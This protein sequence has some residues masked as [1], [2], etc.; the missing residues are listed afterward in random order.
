KGAYTPEVRSLVREYVDA[1]CA[2]SRVGG[3]L[4]ATGKAFGAAVSHSI[5]RKTVARAV[6]EAG[7]A[8]DIQLGME[9]TLAPALSHSA[10]GTT[11]GGVTH[12][13]R[14]VTMLTP[15]YDD[16]SLP[17]THKNRLLGIEKTLSH[18][19]EAQFTGLRQQ[20]DRISSRFT[21]SPL[22]KRLQLS[23]S[24]DDFA[25]KLR[26][27]HG[28]H[29]KDVIKYARLLQ[30]DWKKSVTRR[31][32]GFEKLS[33]ILPFPEHCT[34]FLS[35]VFDLAISNAGGSDS[36]DG[37]DGEGQT[38]SLM[39]AFLSMVRKLGDIAFEELPENVQHD[40]DWSVRVGCCMH[41]EMNCG[42]GFCDGMADSW[43]RI[44]GAT[45][46][47]L[48]ANKAN[49]NA[50]ARSATDSDAAR[51]AVKES[52]RGGPKS[53]M[54]AGAIYNNKGPDKG[55]Q[56]MFRMYWLPIK[57]IPGSKRLP[58]VNFA[59]TSANRFQTTF[60]AACDLIAYLSEHKTYLYMVRDR[61]EKPRW[62]HMEA[63]LFLSLEDDATVTELCCMA[64]AYNC[65]F[66]PYTR[67]ARR[68]GTNHLDLKKLHDDLLSFIRRAIS[69]PDLLINYSAATVRASWPLPWE[70]SKSITAL[71]EL[72]PTLPFF[73]PVFLAGLVRC[74]ETW[75]RFTTEFADDGLIAR[76]TP[77]ER[78]TPSTND[79]N[80]G[81]LG[82]TRLETGAHPTQTIELT[83]AKI[84]RNHNGTEKF[85]KVFFGP[86]DHRSVMATQRVAEASGASG[87]F[88]DLFLDASAQ[89]VATKRAAAEKKARLLAEKMA[90]LAAVGLVLDESVIRRMLDAQ[91]QVQLEVYRTIVKDTEVPIKARLKRKPE[92]L[93][94]VI[95]A[96]QRY[97]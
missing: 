86:D 89:A 85:M 70:H 52:S 56:D 76:S 87:V 5:S 74:L 15:N 19:A 20:L 95:A 29:A 1:G 25:R 45:P 68:E 96:L 75:E 91:L 54:L 81:S 11:I 61:K 18:T 9:M 3:L 77:L 82:E 60:V 40:L 35:A 79:A 39:D 17:F 16:L 63:N 34:T 69:N 72:M 46:P 57:T 53:T 73:Q 88:R 37:L 84:E 59:D 50:I 83:S 27:V 4:L 43:D 65:I 62:S 93:E 36:W 32:L 51:K 58:S 14:R 26:V 21:N 71:H 92:R 31:D 12:E 97:K 67:Q 23:F 33:T 24:P 2:Q 47:V 38:A 48:L 22:A 94:Q 55:H 80:E 10:D 49:A 8:S 66:A 42:K 44:E 30:E 13:S 90:R 41:K 28:D 64:L 78:F 7:I 6:R